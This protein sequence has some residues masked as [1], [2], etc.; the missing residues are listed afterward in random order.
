[1]KI[2]PRTRINFLVIL[3]SSAA[4]VIKELDSPSFPAAI[5][6]DFMQAVFPPRCQAS[7]RKLRKLLFLLYC[8]GN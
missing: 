6:L 4:V 3:I 2:D 1:M 8:I 7:I 5:G